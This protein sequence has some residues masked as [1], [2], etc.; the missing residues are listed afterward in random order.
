MKEYKENNQNLE[1][2]KI[3]QLLKRTVGFSLK[4]TG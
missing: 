4:K 3:L 1:K 2:K